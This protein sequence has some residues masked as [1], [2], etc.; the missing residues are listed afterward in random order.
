[1]RTAARHVGTTRDGGAE[2][3][4]GN[5]SAAPRD[6]NSYGNALSLFRRV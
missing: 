6:G 2:T 5:G 3:G 4:T 1:M